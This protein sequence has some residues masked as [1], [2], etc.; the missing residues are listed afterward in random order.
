MH[1]IRTALLT[2]LVIISAVFGMAPT[3]HAD[4]NDDKAI[5]RINVAIEK[6]WE[7]FEDN[8]PNTKA[9][10]QDFA[11][12]AEE[13][14]KQMATAYYAMGHTT[15]SGT[16]AAAVLDLRRGISVMHSEL[17]KWRLAAQAN[18]QKAFE[19]GNGRFNT[20]IDRYN[21]AIDRYNETAVD[22]P[23]G[24]AATQW[25]FRLVLL[26]TALLSAAAFWWAY[27]GK[28]KAVRKPERR[29]VAKQSLWPL[30]GALVNYILYFHTPLPVY[31]VFLGLVLAGFVPFGLAFKAYRRAA[32]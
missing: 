20:A 14:R 4:A 12:K 16:A 7:A 18:D 24:L 8:K 27:K 30:A 19:L 2:A 32:A 29:K 13:T 3:A 9:F 6:L 11:A 10:Y 5:D 25:L 15:E 23:A 22:A 1:K 31:Y 26:S 21:A 28:H 17:G